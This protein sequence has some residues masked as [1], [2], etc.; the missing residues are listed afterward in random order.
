VNFG[1][2]PPLKLI[3]GGKPEHPD[4][5]LAQRLRMIAL[6]LWLVAG[7]VTWV[8]DPSFLNLAM[9]GGTICFALAMIVEN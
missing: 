1:K 2:R 8:K 5:I 6:G 7:M 4:K 9:F 3:K